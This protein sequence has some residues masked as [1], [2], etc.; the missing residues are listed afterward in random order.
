MSA[1]L[2]RMFFFSYLTIDVVGLTGHHNRNIWGDRDS[3]LWVYKQRISGRN[4]RGTPDILVA[5]R[6]VARI[7]LPDD[8]ITG[9]DLYLHER[10]GSRTH[11]TG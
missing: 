9:V 6:G 4:R 1:F 3:G 5:T 7:L 8:D 2:R 11:R 10:A